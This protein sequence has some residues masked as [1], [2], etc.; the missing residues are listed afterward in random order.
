MAGLNI[1]HGKHCVLEQGQEAMN[2]LPHLAM[3]TLFLR[4]S[5]LN[6]AHTLFSI[7]GSKHPRF[8]GKDAFPNKRYL[9]H[10]IA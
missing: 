9:P 2:R 5:Y 6:E 1:R 4:S 3:T 10:D 7:V 8:W